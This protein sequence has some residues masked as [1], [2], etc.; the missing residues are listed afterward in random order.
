MVNSSYFTQYWSSIN[1]Y[2]EHFCPFWSCKLLIS[3]MHSCYFKSHKQWIFTWS[4]E[5]QYSG[6]VREVM[7]F[8][9]HIELYKDFSVIANLWFFYVICIGSHTLSIKLLKAFNLKLL[10]SFFFSDLSVW[11]FSKAKLLT[12]MCGYICLRKIKQENYKVPLGV[13]EF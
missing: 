2:S 4:I 9:F 10:L 13:S 3:V 5:T 6:I 8:L 7:A 1:L 11:K 12:W